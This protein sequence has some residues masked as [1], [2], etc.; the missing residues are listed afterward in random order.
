[1][2]TLFSS[3]SLPFLPVSGVP[4]GAPPTA[5]AG[6]A[7]RALQALRERDAR[8]AEAALARARGER[9]Q[10]RAG[11]ATP[12]ARARLARLEALLPALER[13]ATALRRRVGGPARA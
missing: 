11:I 4:R 6:R 8:L 12:Y 3:R 1:M 10:L 2:I 9:A 13:A 7:E 5:R